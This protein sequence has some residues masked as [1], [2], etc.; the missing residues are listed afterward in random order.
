MIEANLNVSSDIALFGVSFVC[1][2]IGSVSR[3]DELFV[4]P[5]GASNQKR[6]LI[7]TDKFGQPI[8]SDPDGRPWRRL[9]EKPKT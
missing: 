2:L 6:H 8:M 1:I 5:K 9:R 4:K 3:L 7:G